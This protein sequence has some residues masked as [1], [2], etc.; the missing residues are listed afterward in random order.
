MTTAGRCLLLAVRIGHHVL[1]RLRTQVI[2]PG[3]ARDP[4]G[5]QRNREPGPLSRGCIE[6]TRPHG[7]FHRVLDRSLAVAGDT[8]GAWAHPDHA[9]IG[10]VSDDIET[11][12]FKKRAYWFDAGGLRRSMEQIARTFSV[13]LVVTRETKKRLIVEFE[14]AVTGQ[15][16]RIEDF[17]A[18]TGAGKGTTDWIQLLTSG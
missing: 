12:A 10:G 9:N 6:V 1:S 3:S 5:L 17:R 13:Q 18:A 15:P 11:Y 14:F 7:R 2:Q 4:T 16:D 8:P